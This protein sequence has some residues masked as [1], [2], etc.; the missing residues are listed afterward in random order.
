MQ[1]QKTQQPTISW[2]HL[3]LYR[4]LTE[5]ILFMG[6]PRPGIIDTGAALLVSAHTERD[7]A[8][9]LSLFLAGRCPVL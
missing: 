7:R 1:E 3:P 6:V 4:S 9:C 8:F 5:Y 2:T